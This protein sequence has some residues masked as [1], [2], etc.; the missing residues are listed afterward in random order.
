M[1]KEEDKFPLNIWPEIEQAPDDYRLLERVPF[2][3]FG[4][5]PELPIKIAEPVGDELPLIILD[6]E[7]TGLNPSCDQMIELAMVRALYSPSLGD[8]TSITAIYD[9]FEDPHIEIPPKVTELTGITTEMVKGQKFDLDAVNRLLADDPLVIAHNAGF[10]RLFFD[11]RFCGSEFLTQLRWTCTLKN[12]QWANL[13]G[14]LRFSRKLGNMLFNLN[15]FFEAHR[16]NADCLALLWLLHIVPNA[17]RHLIDNTF[18]RQISLVLAHGLPIE[19]KDRV[20]SRRYNWNRVD[21]VW[22]I[23]CNTPEQVQEE[24]KFLRELYDPEGRLVEEVKLN[25]DPRIC[26]KG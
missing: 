22:N 25:L 7:T 21:K 1:M 26:F 16:A 9:E 14:R 11:R 12:M 18:N 17:F 20:K 15:Y 10:D 6:S 24:L 23:Q 19:Y 3:M 2:T 4:E 5:Q 13:D 8:I